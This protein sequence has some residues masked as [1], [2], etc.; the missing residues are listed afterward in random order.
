MRNT[1]I[2]EAI[3]FDQVTV[4]NTGFQRHHEKVQFW[5]KTTSNATICFTL[6]DQKCF[7]RQKH[8]SKLPTDMDSILSNNNIENSMRANVGAISET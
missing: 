1:R 8:F 4:S 7:R 5:K 6:G 3:T 2:S